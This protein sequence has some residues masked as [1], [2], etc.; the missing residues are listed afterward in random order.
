MA[1]YD[2][3]EEQVYLDDACTDLNPIELSSIL[4]PLLNNFPSFMSLA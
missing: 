1:E 4:F 2:D 3:D